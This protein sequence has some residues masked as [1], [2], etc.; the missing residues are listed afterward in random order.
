M[1]RRNTLAMREA[2]ECGF[3]I[4]G[5][6]MLDKP[7]GRFDAIA[8]PNQW[9]SPIRIGVDSDCL[10]VYSLFAIRESGM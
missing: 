9:R 4:D 10:E 3:E 6:T 7:L 5:C 2:S 1:Q 8:N